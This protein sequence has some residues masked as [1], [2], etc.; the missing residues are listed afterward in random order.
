MQ[1]TYRGTHYHSNP[2][3]TPGNLAEASTE[4]GKYRGVDLPLNRSIETRVLS[5]IELKYR[6]TSYR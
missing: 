5:P 3:V 2:R 1:L 6:G 4:M